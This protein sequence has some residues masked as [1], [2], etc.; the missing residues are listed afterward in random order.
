MYHIFFI[1]SSV[2]GYLDCFYVLAIANN[3]AM[4]IGVYISS[5]IMF[6]SGYIPRSGI[7]RSYNFSFSFQGNCILFSIVAA[8]IYVPTNSLRVL[9]SSTPFP[10]FNVCRLF[11][12]GHFDRVKSYFIVVWICICLIITDIEHF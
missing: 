3:A 6:F 9:L 7:A 10:A 4:T 2:N 12:D 1:H 11:D 8:P 5:I